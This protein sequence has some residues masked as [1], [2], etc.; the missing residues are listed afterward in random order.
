[1]LL[2]KKEQVPRPL[3]SINMGL[4]MVSWHEPTELSSCPIPILPDLPYRG[5]E[6]LVIHGNGNFF[7]FIFPLGSSPS[8][9]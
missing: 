4:V 8:R 7:V 2:V 9:T 6:E 5:E 1:M 3:H